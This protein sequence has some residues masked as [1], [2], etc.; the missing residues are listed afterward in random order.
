MLVS[1]TKDQNNNNDDND[2]ETMMMMM[3]MMMM[4]T[5]NDTGKSHMRC[6]R[7]PGTAEY[8]SDFELTTQIKSKAVATCLVCESVEIKAEW[9]RLRLSFASFFI[10]QQ[11]HN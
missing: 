9:C 5:M 8:V 3:M 2:G 6:S 11:C 10:A 4:K 7:I 1:D